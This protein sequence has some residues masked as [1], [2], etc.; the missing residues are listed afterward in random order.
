MAHLDVPDWNTRMTILR[1]RAALDHI[2]IDDAVLEVVAERV[3]DNVRSLEGALIRVVAHHSLTGRELN[4]ELAEAVLDTVHPRPSTTTHG[5]L[6]NHL[7]VVDIQQ[8]VAKAFDITM[9][10][11]TGP[12]RTAM[13]AWARQLAIYLTRELTDLPLQRIGESFGGRNH[14]TILHACKR[15]GD[16]IAVNNEDAADLHKLTELL[17]YQQS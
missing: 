1:K 17:R 15:V 4:R 5:A 13:V 8:V 10:D 9:I 14:A 6:N 16:R 12:G 2:E 11:I 3:T 7:T